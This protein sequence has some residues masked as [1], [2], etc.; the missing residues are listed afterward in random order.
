LM[1]TVSTKDDLLIRYRSIG[2]RLYSHCT[3]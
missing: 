2:K 3:R 1:I